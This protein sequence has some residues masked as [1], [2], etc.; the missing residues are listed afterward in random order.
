MESIADFDDKAALLTGLTISG[1]KNKQK[2][3]GS[4]KATFLLAD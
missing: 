1:Y 2:K 4:Q 3:K